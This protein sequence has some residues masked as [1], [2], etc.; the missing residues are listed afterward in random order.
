MSCRVVSEL[1]EY[2]RDKGVSSR[3]RMCTAR[4]R[5]LCL[6][7]RIPHA[8]SSCWSSPYTPR[9]WVQGTQ[10]IGLDPNPRTGAVHRSK[11]VRKWLSDIVHGETYRRRAV[12]D[13]GLRGG[14]LLFFFWPLSRRHEVPHGDLNVTRSRHQCLQRYPMPSK[15]SWIICTTIRY[16]WGSC[17]FGTVSHH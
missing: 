16:L 8:C 10:D 4:G 2:L 3:C 7:I 1:V 15:R 17:R 5:T 11:T 14:R 9:V 12:H 6:P 13:L